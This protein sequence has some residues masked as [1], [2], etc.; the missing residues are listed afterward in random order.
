[1]IRQ[2]T[3]FN[4]F[5]FTRWPHLILL[6]LNASHFLISVS[7][8]MEILSLVGIMGIL[9]QT[10]AYIKVNQL[11]EYVYQLKSTTF[12][13][14][15]FHFYNKEIA[16]ALVFLADV[17]RIYGTAIQLFLLINCPLNSLLMVALFM[18]VFANH[19]L[20][21]VYI[22]L[23][24]QM[25]FIFVIHFFCITV[26]TKFH[27]PAKAFIYLFVHSKLVKFYCVRERLKLAN[28]IEQFHTK[29]VFTVTYGRYGKITYQSFF[30]H[31][32]FYIKFLLFTYK[33]AISYS[34]M[35]Q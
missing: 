20:V 24:I 19:L 14:R 7:F 10:M 30:K 32:F 23:A 31:I 33:L 25:T 6:L 34:L 28:Y 2:I 15:Q 1:M 12:T 3:K 35:E 29:N 13:Y 11:N 4:L 5:T 8:M 21:L 18:D 17:N 16:F 22:I 9:L 27:T 26:C